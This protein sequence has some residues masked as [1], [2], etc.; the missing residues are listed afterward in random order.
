MTSEALLSSRDNM[1]R[2]NPDRSHGIVI[3]FVSPDFPTPARQCHPDHLFLCVIPTVFSCIIPTEVEGSQPTSALRPKD[4]IETEAPYKCILSDFLTP[5]CIRSMVDSGD[6]MKSSSNSVDGK[7]QVLRRSG[8]IAP[9][10][11]AFGLFFCAP[12]IVNAGGGQELTEVCLPKGLT[13]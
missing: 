4:G 5:D 3:E 9:S 11:L 2:R 1:G 7:R 12:L 13:R 6:M 10:L 8:L